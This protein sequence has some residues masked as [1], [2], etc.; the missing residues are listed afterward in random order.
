MRKYLYLLPIYMAFN[1]ETIFAKDPFEIL[2]NDPELRSFVSLH[3][4][5]T[6]EGYQEFRKKISSKIAELDMERCRI[7]LQKPVAESASGDETQLTHFTD[8][9]LAPDDYAGTTFWETFKDQVGRVVKDFKNACKMISG[10]KNDYPADETYWRINW[11]AH[12]ERSEATRKESEDAAGQAME[13]DLLIREVIAKINEIERLKSDISREC[14]Q[15][16]QDALETLKR[17]Q[18]LG[19]IDGYKAV[20]ETPDEISIPKLELRKQQLAQSIQHLEIE[21]QA[22]LRKQE[23]LEN[24]AGLWL[25]YYKTS[26]LFDAGTI[27]RPQTVVG[28]DPLYYV[29]N[30]QDMLFPFDRGVSD[31]ETPDRL[32]PGKDIGPIIREIKQLLQDLAGLA[33]PPQT[34][35]K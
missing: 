24:A 21:K 4:Y 33:S 7:T 3:T 5:P 9:S 25:S 15:A 14:A 29:K 23:G 30:V 2:I 22:H 35:A 32:F 13:C 6:I 1:F 17:T 12:H 20:E 19:E 8:V 26:S 10:L 28:H 16:D 18:G 27:I 34:A 11:H 31:Q